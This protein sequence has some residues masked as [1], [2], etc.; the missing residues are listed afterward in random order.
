VRIADGVW[1]GQLVGTATNKS[2]A[3]PGPG[4]AVYTVLSGRFDAVP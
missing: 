2:D 4:A 3:Y 1:Y